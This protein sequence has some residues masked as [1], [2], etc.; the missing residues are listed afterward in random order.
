MRQTLSAAISE[1][2]SALAVERNFSPQTIRAYRADLERFRRFWEEE[3]A[4]E[5]AESTPLTRIDTLAVRAHVA[6]LHRAKLSH[7]SLARHLSAVRSMFAWACR[8][9]WCAVNPASGLPT[10][11]RP[12][13]LP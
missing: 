2:L 5:A 9:G 12:K 3:F 8:S 1:Y 4:H 7:R 13:T 11:R 10:R 6:S